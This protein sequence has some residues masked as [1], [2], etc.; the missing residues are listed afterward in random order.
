MWYNKITLSPSGFEYV[1]L[2]TTY[3]KER[4]IMKMKKRRSNNETV[5]HNKTLC[6]VAG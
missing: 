2:K 4:P 1:L 6:K 5:D 3:R